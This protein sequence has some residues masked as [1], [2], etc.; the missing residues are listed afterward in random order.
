MNQDNLQRT[1]QEYI[2]E[3]LS[4]DRHN[5]G[6]RDYLFS[7]HLNS[8]WKEHSQQTTEF[9]DFTTYLLKATDPHISHPGFN[10]KNIEHGNIWDKHV[11]I[12]EDRVKLLDCVY[13]EIHK[14][15]CTRDARYKDVIS[16]LDDGSKMFFA[17]IAGY[18][19]N[20]VGVAEAA[21]TA[22]VATVFYLIIK[23]GLGA[24]CTYVTQRLSSQRR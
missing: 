6:S 20:A 10:D 8:F 16:H 9:D 7:S 4:S 24:F 11:R 22:T 18:V 12:Y 17:A 19:T 1:V 13:F 23:I 21:A 2:D 3:F 14:A 15:L 5:S